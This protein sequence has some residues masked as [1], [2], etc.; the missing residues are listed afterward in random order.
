MS[1][2]STKDRNSSKGE[3]SCGGGLFWGEKELVF[4]WTTGMDGG[5]FWGSDG[6]GWFKM[7]GLFILLNWTWLKLF[8]WSCMLLF[9]ADGRLLFWDGWKALGNG[10][11]K[12]FWCFGA[13]LLRMA[14]RYWG[15]CK[16]FVADGRLLFWDGWKALGS[17]ELKAFWGFG[18]GLLRMATRYWGDCI[19]WIWLEDGF[20]FE[21]MMGLTGLEAF[22]VLAGLTCLLKGLLFL[23]L[24]LSNALFGV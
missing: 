23:R 9:V 1:Y 17:W 2:P 11:L 8:D 7:G 13:G 18:A 10:L 6:F 21:W 4:C 15:D 20:G 19:L 16:L 24:L 12:A 14:T 3:S 5:L 22:C